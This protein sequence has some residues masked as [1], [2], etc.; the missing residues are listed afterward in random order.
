[1]AEPRIISKEKPIGDEAQIANMS[2][3]DF[4]LLL[5]EARI[6]TERSA[7]EASESIKPQRLR[8]RSG[9]H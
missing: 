8:E 6:I 3:L 7:I 2:R 9:M 4:L 5:W 1:M